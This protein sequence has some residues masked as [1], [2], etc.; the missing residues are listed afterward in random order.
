MNPQQTEFNTA[1]ANLTPKQKLKYTKANPNIGVGEVQQSFTGNSYQPISNLIT[2]GDLTGNQNL[3]PVPPKPVSGTGYVPS[4]TQPTTTTDNNGLATYT[5][6]APAPATDTGKS[7]YKQQLDQIS[8]DLGILDT[9]PIE[10]TKIQEAQQLATK[11]EQATKDYNS[12]VLKKREIEKKLNEMQTAEANTVGGVGGG[13]SSKIQEYQRKSNA[14]LADLAIQAQASQGLLDAAR[15][16]IKDTLDA[17]FSP[18]EDRIK[19]RAQFAQLASNDLTDSEKYKLDQ[20]N[21]KD[22]ANQKEVSTFATSL[23]NTVFE[24]GA[25]VGVRTKIFQIAG[26]YASGNL[27]KE[28]ALSKMTESAGSYGIK[29]SASEK[30]P[31]IQKINGVDMQWNPT[32]EKWE[33]PSTTSI[34]KIDKS[35][36]TLAQNQTSINDVDQLLKGGAGFDTAVGTSILTRSTGI[37]GNLAKIGLGLATGAGAGAA[38]GAPF[39]GVGAI[40]GS[41]GG[42]IIGAGTALFGIGKQAYSQLSGAEQDFIGS[43]EQLR[44]NLNLDSLIDAKSRG[45][46]FGALSDQ[47]LKVLSNAATKIGQWAIK[48]S[49]GNVVGYNVSQGAFKKELEKINNFAKLDYIIKGGDPMDVNAQMQSDGSIWVKN[50]DGTLTKIK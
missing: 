37:F 48:D 27:T 9:K 2:T 23:V 29:T 47:E 1:L 7:V 19:L 43:V 20:L 14:E 34:G 35:A 26:D 28:Q 46:T 21:K 31:T 18:I 39:A 42:A 49:N 15:Q 30:A 4:V 13:Y 38:A 5:P 3:I 50:S 16:T 6:P 45:A 11:T 25:P 36:S 8:K 17:Q 24:N 32:S 10:A 22:E 33:T 40:P 12:Y 41:I 44:S